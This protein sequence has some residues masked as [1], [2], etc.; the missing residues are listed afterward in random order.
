MGMFLAS[1]TEYFSVRTYNTAV[2]FH[3]CKWDDG[4]C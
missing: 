3:T 1:V 4:S 2:L